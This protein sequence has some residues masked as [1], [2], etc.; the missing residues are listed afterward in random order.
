MYPGF[1]G[2]LLVSKISR[3]SVTRSPLP[4]PLRFGAKG[5][6]I[7]E[8]N[9]S[10]LLEKALKAFTSHFKFEQTFVFLH[11]IFLG[12]R[13]WT[14]IPHPRY[15]SPAGY[16]AE[17]AVK[18]LEPKFSQWGSFNYYVRKISEAYQGVRNVSVSENFALVLNE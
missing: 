9:T 11:F 13:V 3:F 1:Q 12:A 2:I 5:P 15:Q 8:F 10:A 18:S 7:F 6:N 14:P 4:G 16:I 17:I